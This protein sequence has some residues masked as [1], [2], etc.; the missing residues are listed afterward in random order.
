MESRPFLSRIPDGN[1]IV[2]DR[3]ETCIPGEGRY[4]FAATRDE[5]GSYAMVYVPV[6]RKFYVRTS[7]LRAK[8]IKALVV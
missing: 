5:E 1:L 3:V 7:L 2:K 6:G 4:H 8:K